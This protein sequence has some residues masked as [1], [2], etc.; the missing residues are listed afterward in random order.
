[1]ADAH[2]ENKEQELRDKMSRFLTGDSL[3]RKP[4]RDVLHQMT[5]CH[6]NAFLF[7]GVARDILRFGIKARVR[8]VDVV[9]DAPA[10]A[11]YEHLQTYVKRR[12]RFGGL[13]MV[14]ERWLFDV[15]PLA[16]TWA[17]RECH[18]AH[19]DFERLPKTTFLN[20]EAVAVELKPRRGRKRS[21][22]SHGFFEAF[23]N[24]VVDINLR[25]NPYPGLCVVRS[26]LTA[27]RLDFA[28]GITLADYILEEFGN[29]DIEQFLSVQKSH[30]GCHMVGKHQLL[31]WIHDIRDQR[32][33]QPAS[34]IRLSHR[35][36]DQL[37]LS[38]DIILAGR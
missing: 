7:G 20:V 12:T 15:W 31:H 1:M 37:D 33:T 23:L 21:I 5:C 35:L 11:L 6:W 38:D 26:L 2:I 19:A 13:H 8:D 22:Y 30:Y 10:N 36:P 27:E 25:E 14:N 34:N 18:I 3:R 9:A 17:F 28:I 4:V 16:D 29:T 32:K 24:E